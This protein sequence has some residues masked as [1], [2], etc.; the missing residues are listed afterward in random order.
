MWIV[1]VRSRPPRRQPVPH[2][3]EDPRD[4]KVVGVVLEPKFA[5]R[6]PDLPPSCPALPTLAVNG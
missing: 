5:M 3:N 1:V 4:G 2:K 6:L